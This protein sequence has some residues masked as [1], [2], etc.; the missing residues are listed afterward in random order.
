LTPVSETIDSL[1]Q[2]LDS[3]EQSDELTRL[4]ANTYQKTASYIQ[5]L[6][7]SADLGS[8]DPGSRLA[9]K[10]LWLIEGMG[11][12]LLD[13]RLSKVSLT[14]N[15]R[16]LLPEEKFVYELR[17][18][19]ER[20]RTRF[21]DALTNG[22]PSVFATLQKEQMQKTVL[23]SFQRPMGEIIGFDLNKYGPFKVHDVARLPA[24]NAEVLVLNGDATRV[25]SSEPSQE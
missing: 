19:F 7:K 13:K 24:V 25:Y 17:S 9:R 11:R 21:T 12:Q 22:Q 15:S 8:G 5:K 3:E 14:G 10:Q 6:R 20:L 1:K 23:V 4:P 16:L 2:L 18:E